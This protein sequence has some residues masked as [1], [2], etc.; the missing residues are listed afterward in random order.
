MKHPVVLIDAGNGYMTPW[1][2]ENVLAELRRLCA[3]KASTRE[4]AA[5]L[6]VMFDYQFSRNAV[7]GIMH[8]LGLDNGYQ[9]RVSERKR[10]AAAK[11]TKREPRKPKP[12]PEP[13]PYKKRKPGRVCFLMGYR[14]Y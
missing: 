12:T 3:G 7:V 13:L 11:A 4:I 5:E 14:G 9:A 8:R 1:R 10:Q 2:D 6:S